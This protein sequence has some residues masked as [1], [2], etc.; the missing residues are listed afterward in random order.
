M[1]IIIKNKMK[2]AAKDEACLADVWNTAG[3]NYVSTDAFSQQF[4]QTAVH[5]TTYI[6]LHMHEQDTDGQ[7]T[8]QNTEY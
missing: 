3:P 1:K 5:T 2:S 7:K 6:S 8:E 4:N